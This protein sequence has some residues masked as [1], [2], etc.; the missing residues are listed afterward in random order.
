MSCFFLF[1]AFYYLTDHRV[2]DGVV[3]QF[4]ALNVSTHILLL[5]SGFFMYFSMWAFIL[6][7]APAISSSEYLAINNHNW[8]QIH[9]KALPS[10]LDCHGHSLPLP[11]FWVLGCLQ[12]EPSHVL[13]R[14]HAGSILNKAGTISGQNLLS[15]WKIFLK[16]FNKC[17]G[18]LKGRNPIISCKAITVPCLSWGPTS[19]WAP[20]LTWSRPL[21]GISASGPFLP[22]CSE[23]WP[24]LRD[25]P[26][27]G[28][29]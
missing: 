14:H 26:F 15:V 10:P 28:S 1:C 2:F 13:P 17:N 20:G 5:H 22:H 12:Y 25:S 24:V 23:C 21:S 18:P 7:M 8:M 4:M 11:L 29:Y 6:S 16:T 3:I 19:R 27:C 9:I